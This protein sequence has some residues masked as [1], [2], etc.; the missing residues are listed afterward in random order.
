MTSNVH[1]FFQRCI[2][3]VSDIRGSIDIAR[4]LLITRLKVSVVSLLI[5]WA[6]AALGALVSFSAVAQSSPEVEAPKPSDV[7][8]VIDI[9]GSMKK[10]DPKNLRRPALD[11][12]VK[13]LP[14]G[15]KA[16]VWSFGQYVNLLV[17]HEVVDKSWA[18][19][20][21]AAASKISSIAQ[22]TN[23]GEA[24]EKAA[25][26]VAQP[27]DNYQKHIILLTDGMVDINRD[28]SY[29]Q[30][31]RLRIINDVLPM[32]EKAGYTLHTI[33]LSDNADQTLLKKLAI[34][35]DGKVAIAK[36]AEELMNAFLQVFDQA[37]PSEELPFDGESFLVDSSIEE[38]TAL[39]FRK[40]N[41][42]DTVIIAPDG[43]QY[44]SDTRNDY[45]SWF[46]TQ[47]YD[48]V[49]IKQP[50]EGEW[51]LAADVEPQSRITVVSDLSLVVNRLPTN[52]S[53]DELVSASLA[54]KEDNKNVTRVEF[55]GLLDIDVIVTSDSGKKWTQRLSD[56]LIPRD[57]VYAIDIDQFDE[58]GQYQLQFA[59]DGK[60]FTRQ[61][62]HNLSVR[63]P[64]DVKVEQL[65][66]QGK[67]QFMV[68]V[69]PQSS[70]INVAETSV[71]GDIQKPSGRNQFIPF[72]PT[73]DGQ[74]EL[75]ITPEEQGDYL[76]SVNVQ[77]NDNG[78]SSET[79]LKTIR[80]SQESGD[81]S[82]V[83]PVAAAPVVPPAMADKSPLSTDNEMVNEDEVIEEPIE[84]A[85]ESSFDIMQWVI[86]GAVALV[87][88]L[89]VFGIYLIYRKLFKKKVDDD[90][91]EDVDS[92]EDD[93]FK[94][95]P[96]DEM[97]VEDLEDEEVAAA[98]KEMADSL[99]S[100]L[101]SPDAL[102]DMPSD[103]M[104]LDEQTEDIDIESL[105][106][107]NGISGFDL[108]D[109]SSTEEVPEFSLDDFSPE[110]IDDED[111]EGDK[112]E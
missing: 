111:I 25:Y 53:V 88:L 82:E 38:F 100:D 42:K 37:V 77:I 22:Y 19:K 1:Y 87:N 36:T 75:A 110:S 91:E 39:I 44:N 112:K 101:V 27:D 57:G 55:L 5:V 10:N 33:A 80:L 109:D 56:D 21:S 7:R 79:T 105:D 51:K 30:A 32:Y 86:Y 23:I 58:E 64:F 35:T 84:P 92:E 50:I 62:T 89:V 16:G 73:A 96:M 13:L 61:F 43:Q 15:S 9:S 69:I 3:M 93:P 65:T 99:A 48:L 18:S 67:T 17:D 94:E 102:D 46:S 108:D 63:K 59:V 11:M 85:E 74:W 20:A 90:T 66:L 78:Q 47:E 2:A 71:I 106:D 12:M 103:D 95:P 24:L 31:E 34:A 76:L 29:N 28:S 6:F 68:S 40:P 70:T 60:S 41:A 26:D 54:L 72:T 4:L 83:E 52:V 8:M 14:E 81:F 97:A 104:P 45:V 98:E 107:E 49:T